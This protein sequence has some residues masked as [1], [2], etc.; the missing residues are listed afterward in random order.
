MFDRIVNG[1][2]DC[3]ADVMAYV[4]GHGAIGGRVRSLD[5][6]LNLYRRAQMVDRLREV[7]KKGIEIVILGVDGPHGFVKRRDE[8]LRHGRN[9]LQC[10]LRFLEGNAVSRRTLAKKR[11]VGEPGAEII[12]KISC[13]PQSFA[14]N[15]VFLIHSSKVCAQ[16][17][18]DHC[19]YAKNDC[20]KSE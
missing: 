18:A 4:T 14:L 8:F 2:F 1:F 12:M 20:D 11:D 6:I 5:S 13:N 15:C 3:K 17:R 10:F 7:V 19:T 16:S 9:A